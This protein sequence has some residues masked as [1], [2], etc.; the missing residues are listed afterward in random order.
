MPSTT[1]KKYPK[2]CAVLR[3]KD[4]KESPLTSDDCKAI[5]GWT[6]EGGDDKWSSDFVLKDLFGNKIRLLNNPS[7]RPFKLALAKKYENEHLRGKW[8][9]NLETIVVDENGNVPEGQHRLTGFILAEQRRQLNPKKF[10]KTPLVY[11]TLLGFGVSAKPE[12]ANTYGLGDKRSLGDVIYRHQRFEKEIS[13][14]QQKKVSKIL[15]GAIR[16]VWLRAGGQQVSFAPH[17]PHS[18]ALEFYGKHPKVLE[19]VYTMLENESATDKQVSS[20]LSLSY[21]SALLYIM[22]KAESVEKAQKFWSSF[23]SGEGLGKNS[24]ILILRQLLVRMEASSG[25]KRDEIIGAVVKAWLLWN[26]NKKATT[27]KDIKVNRKKQGDRLILSEF[28]RIGGIDSPIEKVTVELTDPQLLILSILETQ[29]EEI[30]Y[31]DLHDKTGLQVGTLATAIMSETK[32]GKENPHSLMSREL[33]SGCQY[34]AE[35]GGDTP[36]MFKLSAKG[37]KYVS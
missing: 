12:N 2:I 19:S 35:E 21:A 5:I 32:Q 17:F 10:G 31:K 22:G 28:P 15:A 6:E 3:S 9:L 33:V 29:K 24:P 11:E 7:N 1:K 30:T 14:K 26:K 34:E 18:E 13:D 20:L 37:R 36:Y 27:S 16:L 4:S 8:S 23:A 25:N